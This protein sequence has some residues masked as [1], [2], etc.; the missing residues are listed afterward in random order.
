MTEFVTL[1]EDFLY[2]L[3]A[4]VLAFTAYNA[5]ERYMDRQD[6][7]DVLRSIADTHQMTMQSMLGI[8]SVSKTHKAIRES[9]EKEPQS[10]GGK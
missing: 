6:R 10:N 1:F 3:T 2:V 7:K 8:H 9:E 5:Y 4:S